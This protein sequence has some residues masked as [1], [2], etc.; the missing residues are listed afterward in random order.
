MYTINMGGNTMPSYNASSQGISWTAGPAGGPIWCL[1]SAS[2]YNFTFEV[3]SVNANIYNCSMNLTMINGTQIA[4][5]TGCNSSY[6]AAGTGGLIYTLVNTSALGI[7][8]KILGEYLVTIINANGTIQTLRLEGDARWICIPTRGTGI[9]LKDALK[10]LVSLP[11]WGTNPQTTDFS[12]I[13]F[14]FLFMAIALAILNF[15]T[16]YDTA[17]PGSFVYIITGLVIVMS[18][19]NGLR[20]P[21]FFYLSGATSPNVFNVVGLGSFSAVADNWILPVHFILL[22]ILYLFTTMKRYQA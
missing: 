19:A 16:G 4:Y 5:V 20:G 2:V 17:Y 18:L 9:S 13:V 21:G 14:F 6:P 3:S 11:E 8:D 22:S 1:L 10:D 15:F 7:T 12:K